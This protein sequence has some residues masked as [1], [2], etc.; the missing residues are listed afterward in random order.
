MNNLKD[1]LVFIGDVYYPIGGFEEFKD[2]FDTRKEAKEFVEE[3]VEPTDYKWG[4]VAYI[5]ED[6][7]ENWIERYTPNPDKEKGEWDAVK[8]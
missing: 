8:F 3:K 5:G 1:Y 4:Q 7:N 2:S 6:P